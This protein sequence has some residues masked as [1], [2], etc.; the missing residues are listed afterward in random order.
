[1]KSLVLAFG[2]A[3]TVAACGPAAAGEACEE[4]GHTD[5]CVAGAVC[6][7][8]SG[9]DE[10]AGGGEKICLL[11]GNNDSEREQESRT[12]PGEGIVAGSKEGDRSLLVAS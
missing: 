9:G 5:G 11:I 1:M 7:K 10:E 12:E 4:K 2:F 3:L 8:V 6:D